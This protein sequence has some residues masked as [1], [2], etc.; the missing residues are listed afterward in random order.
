MSAHAFTVLGLFELAVVASW[1]VLAWTWRKQ[2]PVRALTAFAVV[3]VLGET[4][5]IVVHGHTTELAQFLAFTAV[6]LFAARVCIDRDARSRLLPQ[7]TL[8][9]LTR[10]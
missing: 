3:V 5:E 9:R 6:S 10:R 8:R 1:K 7:R 4:A 2:G